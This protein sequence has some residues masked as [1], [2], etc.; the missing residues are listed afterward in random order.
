[1]IWDFELGVDKIKLVGADNGP[2]QTTDR[3][4]AAWDDPTQP[5]DNKSFIPG[6]W[7]LSAVDAHSIIFIA[8]QSLTAAELYAADTFVV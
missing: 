7:I 3:F 1:M 5:P 6:T 4:L 8:G 2:I